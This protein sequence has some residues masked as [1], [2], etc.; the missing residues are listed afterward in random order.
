MAALSTAD[1]ESLRFASGTFDGWTVEGESTWSIGRN[2]ELLTNPGDPPRFVADSLFKGEQHTGVLRSRPFVVAKGYQR[3][4]IAGWDGTAG[5]VNDGDRNFVLLRSHPDGEVLR[6][7]HT[8]GGNK[9]VP[10]KWDTHDLIGRQVY[11]EV[12]DA[13][14]VIRP[15]GFAWI[16]FADYRQEES[17]A[18]KAPVRR[19]DLYGVRIDDGAERV[20]CRTLPFLAAHPGKRGKTRRQVAGERETIPVGTAAE[21]VYLLGMINEG[22]D[23]GLAHWGEHPEL[24]TTRDDQVHIG[25]RI[26]D[27]EIRYAGG[28][29]DR[30]PVRIGATAWFVAQWAHGPTHGISTPIR[31]PFASRPDCA[32]LLAKALRI[33]EST[34]VGGEDNR[35]A[36]YFLGIRP[37]PEPVESIIVYDNPAVRGRPLV[38]AITLAAPKATEGLLPFGTWRADASDLQP[39]FESRA[40]GDWSGDLVALADALYTREADLPRKV[41]VIDLPDG[42]KAARIRFTGGV[43]ADMLSNL[44]TANLAQIDSKFERDTGFFHETGKD[45]PWYGGYSGVGTWAPIGVYHAAAAPRCSDHFASL[46]LRCIRDEVRNTNYVDFVDKWF[47]FY[48]DNHDPTK[49]PPNDHLDVARYP[50]GVPGHWMFIIPPSGPPVQINEI[51]GEEEMD[52]HGATMVARWLVWRTM[53][54]RADAWLREPRAKVYGKSRWDTTREAAEFVCWLMDHTG[55]DVMWSEGETTGWGGFAPWG[56]RLTGV[57]DWYNETDP[58]KIRRNYANAD[59]YEP[60]PTYVCLTA[61]RCSAQIAD[62]MKDEAGAKKWRQY[63]DRL[64]SGMIRLL[65]HGPDGLREWKQSRFS[66]YPSMQDSLVQAWFAFYHDGLDPQRLHPEMTAITR[67]TLRRQLSYPYGRRPVL[68]MGYGMGWLT[69]AALILDELDDAG[70]LLVNIAKYSYDK[71]MDYA[72]PAR[73]IDWR[74]WL[75]LIPE[76]T[77]LLP[78]GRWHRIGDLTN[79]ANQGPAMHAIELCAGIDDT[80]PAELKILPRVPDPL[81]GIEVCDF[82]TLVPDGDGLARV[83]VRYSYNR[84]S[85]AFR[86]RSDRPL[87]ALAVRLGPFDEAGARA[88]AESI[89]CPAGAATRIER[90]G[91]AGGRDAWWVWVEGLR[92][93]AAAEF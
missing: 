50:K 67:N 82:P 54:G 21:S 22:W 59:M 7:T 92:D 90:S 48:R 53:G 9:L 91:R 39:A 34:E 28:A 33:R 63:A 31:E 77:N 2:P 62:A 26:G 47:Y 89:Q 60:Y 17:P 66:V 57:H 36:H 87:P 11:V 74:K 46:A 16:A 51:P 3:F 27:L 37:R 64:Q 78:D 15:G 13:N 1:D 30:I 72:D 35:H 14:P 71:N 23:Y 25:T 79:G 61:L 55:R 43:E 42:L 52:G 80:R 88:R 38:S 4:S 8:P 49:G 76:G 86:L 81:T 56:I 69:K 18:M 85:G 44:W 41:D 6:R 19:D 24:R 65:A 45:C 84:A 68:A 32:A 93:A 40:P 75:W 58:A 83:N 12:V 20:V 73:G 5:G 29:A 70:P 10:A